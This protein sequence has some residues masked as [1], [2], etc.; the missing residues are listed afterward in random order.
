MKAVYSFWDQPSSDEHVGYR[1]RRAMLEGWSLSVAMS[2]EFYDPVLYIDESG[3]EKINHLGLPWSDVNFV[4]FDDMKVHESLWCFPKLWAV[5]ETEPP[6]VH[7][8]FDVYLHKPLPDFDYMLF[9]HREEIGGYNY[10][11]RDAVNTVENNEAFSPKPVIWNPNIDYAYNCGV[12]GCKDREWKNTWTE[13][14][15]DWVLD[16]EFSGGLEEGIHDASEEWSSF[17]F[18]TLI[19]QYMA[20]CTEDY[21]DKKA[22]TLAGGYHNIREN[23]EE[24]GY[25]HLVGTSKRDPENEEIVSNFLKE[26]YPQLHKEIND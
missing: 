4:E 14:V 23:A 1:T 7:V 19:E 10:F 18:P 21:L 15:I 12:I 26:K 20:A 8:D 17:F 16:D 11:Y 5:R 22:E 6:F 25:T 2:N 24:I 3:W 13:S 9:Q